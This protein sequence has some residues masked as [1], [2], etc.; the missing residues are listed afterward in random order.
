MEVSLF[1]GALGE[2]RHDWCAV[3]IELLKLTVRNKLTSLC[4]VMRLITSTVLVES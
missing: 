4:E 2:V 3:N 1:S